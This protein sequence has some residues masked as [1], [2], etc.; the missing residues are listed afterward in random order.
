MELGTETAKGAAEKVLGV[1]LPILMRMVLPGLLATAVL[2]PAVGWA[3]GHLPGDPDHSWQRIAAYAA[4][5]FVLGALISTLSSEIYKVYEGRI[6]WPRRLKEWARK[7]QQLRVDYLCQAAEAPGVGDAERAE[8]YYQLR[9]YPQNDKGDREATH[10]TRIGNILAG[11]EQYPGSRYNMDSVFY[12]PRI[13]LQMDREIKEEIDSQWSVADGFLILSAISFGGGILWMVQALTAVFGIGVHELPLGSSGKASWAGVAWIAAGY[14]WYRLSLPFH[15]ENGE[16]FK[17]IFDLYRGKV[18][19]L[20]SL[21]P[22]EEAKWN[23]AWAY[24]Q[25]HLVTC[26]NCGNLTKAESDQC[27]VCGFGL[28]EVKEGLRDTGKFP[29]TT[30]KSNISSLAR[31]IHNVFNRSSRK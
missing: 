24:L 21:K 28:A 16:V 29:G 22:D 19:K 20:T 25:Y 7:R 17:S 31:F 9:V 27:Q 11:Y 8:I 13:W 12:W 14:G 15:R 18:W 6:W 3:L 23:A 30:D 1:K 5:V 2:Y 4:L 26:P 10:P